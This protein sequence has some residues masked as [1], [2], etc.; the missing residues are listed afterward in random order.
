MRK[1]LSCLLAVLIIGLAGAGGLAEESLPELPPEPREEYAYSGTKARQYDSE[2]LQYT[3]EKIK[4][5]GV[6]CYLSKI[7][8]ADPAR[9][10]KKQTAEWR[11]NIQR[12]I[13][14]AKKV[15]GAALVINGSGYVSPVYPWIPENYPG[16]NA[17]YYFTPLGS[18]TVTGGEVFRNLTG[19]PYYGLTLEADGLQMYTGED[20]ETILAR[21]PLETWSFYVNCPM[22]R[23][24]EDLLP[25]DWTFADR[26]ARRT[27]IAR[28]NRNNYLILTVTSE[29]KTGLSL[30]A[31]SA[32]FRE[33]F[34][35]EWVYN[36]DGG[37]SS[38]LICRNKGKTGMKTIYGGTAKDA[39]I[40][41]FLEL[42]G[43]E[44]QKK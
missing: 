5:D 26:R 41:A 4:I 35:T 16:T 36:L 15:K 9:Q 17:D 19:V 43:T 10:I 42:P 12:P 25:E 29:G 2:T 33:N 40:M 13:T 32:F 37:P 8:V 44:E 30:R 3:V 14:L 20:N 6:V 1:R 7:W 21:N 22:L 23:N 28:V 31:V 34:D 24:N 18:L 39:D 27:V 11:K 38:A